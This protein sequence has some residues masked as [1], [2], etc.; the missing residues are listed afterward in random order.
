MNK[1]DNKQCC[2]C[3]WESHKDDFIKLG[4]EDDKI[5]LCQECNTI[6]KFLEDCIGEVLEKATIEGVS[7]YALTNAEVTI[8]VEDADALVKKWLKELKTL[9]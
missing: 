8:D 4:I 2:V 3:G 5:W 9:K 7:E 1:E 6:K